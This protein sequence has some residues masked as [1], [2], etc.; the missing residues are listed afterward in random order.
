MLYLLIN[1]LSQNKIDF[2]LPSDKTDEI[3]YETEP[4]SEDKSYANNGV[5][6]RINFDFLNHK[7]Y[8]KDMGYGFGTYIKVDNTTIQEN[9][10]IN[11]GDTFMIFSYKIFLNF[12]NEKKIN[13]REILLLKI[14]NIKG[15]FEPILLGNDKELYTI[16]RAKDADITINDIML[17]RINCFVYFKNGF[18]K[19]QD[20]NQNGEYS[21]NGTW[22]YAFED[23]EI[24]DNMAF[25]SNK[26]NFC[27]KLTNNNL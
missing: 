3:A 19:I 8:I 20:G 1:N 12:E 26:F 18:W 27:C 4:N 11:I 24:F 9:T 14:Y 16:G 22:I 7:Y 5:L 17:S 6:F 25:K 23:M 21:T 15:E 10:I 13:D 2:V